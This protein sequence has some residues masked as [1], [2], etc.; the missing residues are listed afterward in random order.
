M[1]TV[2]S[3]PASKSGTWSPEDTLLRIMGDPT[4]I[5][6]RAFT[7]SAGLTTGTLT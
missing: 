2:A 5:V 3:N 4:S 7:K 1:L 6:L